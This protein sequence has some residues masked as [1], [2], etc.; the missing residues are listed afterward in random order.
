MIVSSLA[1][2]RQDCFFIG[3]TDWIKGDSLRLSVCIENE[4]KRRIMR[5]V[6]AF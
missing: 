3:V 1:F 2:H 6:Q 5:S 4:T